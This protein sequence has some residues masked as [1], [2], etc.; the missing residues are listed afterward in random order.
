LD[1]G[2]KIAKKIQNAPISARFVTKK[3]CRITGAEFK[4]NPTKIAGFIKIFLEEN[5]P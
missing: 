3:F 2:I 4:R 5:A 1:I